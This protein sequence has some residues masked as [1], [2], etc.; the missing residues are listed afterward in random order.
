[1]SGPF[2]SS[3]WMYNAS[4]GF[5][6]FEI[7]NSLRFDTAS[8]TYLEKD[9]YTH[10]RQIFTYSFWFKPTNPTVRQFIFGR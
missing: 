6:D 10:N 2:G 9:S 3:Q 7:S 8:S 5:Y 4:S 1:M